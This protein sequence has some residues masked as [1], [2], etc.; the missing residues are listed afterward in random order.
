MGPAEPLLLGGSRGHLG[1]WGES[2]RRLEPTWRGQQEKG[3]NCGFVGGALLVGGGSGRLR[4]GGRVPLVG[5]EEGASRAHG[6]SPDSAG[7]GEG[8]LGAARG[9][10]LEDK[11]T[12]WSL[13]LQSGEWAGVCGL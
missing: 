4:R 1:A 11:V 5:E 8:C 12:P 13:L 6:P 7:Q 9:R 10:V 2:R 3:L